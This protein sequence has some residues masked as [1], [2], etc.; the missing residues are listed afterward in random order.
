LGE[1]ER[2][3]VVLHFGHGVGYP[4]LADSFG[5]REGA[6]RMRISRAL[7]RMRAALAADRDDLL[8][9]A[10]TPARALAERAAAFEDAQFDA[11]ETIRARRGPDLDLALDDAEAQDAGETLRAR[12]R[13]DPEVAASSEEPAAL[14]HPVAAVAAPR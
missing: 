14:P 2:A 6:V 10:P 13:C 12:A 5:L 9:A 7:A 1:G 11:A 4:E 3:L 8:G